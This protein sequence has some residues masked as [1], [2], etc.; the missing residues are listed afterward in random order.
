MDNARLLEGV[1]YDAIAV[2]SETGIGID[3]VLAP[4]HTIWMPI[5]AR[6]G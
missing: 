4:V 5:I 6:N 1:I 2:P 3:V